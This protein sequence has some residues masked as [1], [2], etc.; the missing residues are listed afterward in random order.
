MLFMC[1]NS[2]NS[3]EK[4]F[5]QTTDVKGSSSEVLEKKILIQTITS[6][7]KYKSSKHPTPDHFIP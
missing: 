1:S 4:A 7:H 3:G 2:G 5:D 6:G